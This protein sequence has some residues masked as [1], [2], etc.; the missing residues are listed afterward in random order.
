[1]PS[2]F[3]LSYF[4]LIAEEQINQSV[5]H[6]RVID[7]IGKLID[8]NRLIPLDHVDIKSTCEVININAVAGKLRGILNPF[9]IANAISANRFTKPSSSDSR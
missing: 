8:I 1:M 7:V 5:K 6:F 2:S 3:M 4:R 9:V